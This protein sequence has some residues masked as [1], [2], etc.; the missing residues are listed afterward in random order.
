L[1]A[2]LGN[3]DLDS[4]KQI[5]DLVDNIYL[6]PLVQTGSSPC[7]WEDKDLY[8]KRSVLTL[9]PHASPG[10]KTFFE[11]LGT[12]LVLSMY[13][14]CTE[15]CLFYLVHTW[16]V[17]TYTKILVLRRKYVSHRWKNAGVHPIIDVAQ[18]L[19]HHNLLLA[20]LFIA[21]TKVPAMQ[22]LKIVP[23][24]NRTIAALMDATSPHQILWQH[25]YPVR[26][27][28]DHCLHLRP[29]CRQYFVTLFR[30]SQHSNECM[31]LEVLNP[32][33]PEALREEF[34]AVLDKYFV[35]IAKTAGASGSPAPKY[36]RR[37]FDAGEALPGAD[38]AAPA[39][40]AAAL[41]PPTAAPQPPA[42][43]Q[44]EPPLAASPAPA[45]G[46]SGETKA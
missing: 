37:S 27:P 32:M 34:I 43:G 8:D 33:S 15:S 39:P 12:M 20:H 28:Q 18:K 24:K 3:P 23:A 38:A 4:S 25:R 45:R 11:F 22:R 36:F 42:P 16:Y 29:H 2:V 26:D 44:Q 14:V 40:A 9:A 13:S 21:L 41:A 10:Q 35:R 30:R 46:K 31:V 17:F 7:V 5:Y 6:L 19:V 1:S